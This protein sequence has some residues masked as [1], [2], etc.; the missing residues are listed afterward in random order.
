MTAKFPNSDWISATAAMAQYNL[1]NFDEAQELYEDLLDRDPYRID[2]SA[3]KHKPHWQNCPSL[4]SQPH[5]L[6]GK[7]LIYH[8]ASASCRLK[9][10]NAEILVEYSKHLPDGAQV[11][12]LPNDLPLGPHRACCSALEVASHRPFSGLVRACSRSQG[13]L[14]AHGNGLDASTVCN[15]RKWLCRAWTPTATSCT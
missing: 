5:M 10:G 15:L 2:V 1:R 14:A 4:L 7:V 6:C 3:L 8:V 12:F 13:R 11:A 9:A